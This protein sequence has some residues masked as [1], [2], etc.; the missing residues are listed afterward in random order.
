ML[1]LAVYEHRLFL[2]RGNH[3]FVYD[4]WPCFALYMLRLQASKK[5]EPNSLFR[6]FSHSTTISF[7]GVADNL[8]SPCAQ[9]IYHSIILDQVY[10]LKKIENMLRKNIST[11]LLI[12]VI[13]YPNSP[14][15]AYTHPI[16]KPTVFTFFGLKRSYFF[17]GHPTTTG[18]CASSS[19]AGGSGSSSR[20]AARQQKVS[21]S[22]SGQVTAP[23]LHAAAMATEQPDVPTNSAIRKWNQNVFIACIQIEKFKWIKQYLIM[24]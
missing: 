21:T 19:G 2:V 15:V 10:L 6:L 24:L 7:I 9:S 4:H 3:H 13:W 16:K 20:R 17:V 14:Y 8:Y 12:L 18:S 5:N 22:T 23:T 1:Y 11:V